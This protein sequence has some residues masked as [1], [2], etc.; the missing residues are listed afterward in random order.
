MDS[1]DKL[2]VGEYLLMPPDMQTLKDS[3]SFLRIYRE[4]GSIIANN[5]FQNGI[6]EESALKME[7]SIE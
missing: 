1:L 6:N 7:E 3:E 5:F 2:D 4:D